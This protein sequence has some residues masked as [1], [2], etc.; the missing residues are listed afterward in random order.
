MQVEG[1]HAR[2][3]LQLGDSGIVIKDQVFAQVTSLNGKFQTCSGEEGLLGLGFS[4][5]SSHN[6]PTVL[7][8][9]KDILRYPIFAMY[10]DGTDDYPANGVA[11][12]T[13]P[14]GDAGPTPTASGDSGSS[15]YS[16]ATSA[17]S[18]I[19]FGGVNGRLYE[20][21]ITWHGL[22]KFQNMQTGEKFEGYWDFA[23]EKV[24][25]GGLPIP[26]SSLA[27]VD[28]GS[29]FILGPPD[30]VSALAQLDG[31]V[32]LDLTVPTAPQ[33]VPC[34]SAEGFDAAVLDCNSPVFSV[35]LIADGTTYTL[36]KE[37]IVVELDTG[38]DSPICLLRMLPTFEFDGWILGD[39]FLNRHYAAF[40]FGNKKVG[41][42][43]SASSS[44]GA[45]I[46]Q[47][48][49]PMD[50]SNADGG[51]GGMPQEK[52]TSAPSPPTQAATSKAQAAA[53]ISEEE[54]EEPPSTIPETAP[55]TSVQAEKT[56]VSAT[57]ETSPSL[58]STP[59]PPP[60][61]P[62]PPPTLTRGG[63]GVSDAEKMFFGVVGVVAAGIV[64]VLLLTRRRKRYRRAAVFDSYVERHG[65][66]GLDLG[67]ELEMTAGGVLS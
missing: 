53:A 57:T 51:T 27:V 46:C 34:D 41:F 36:A 1:E 18:E 52:G 15:S 33:D 49:W 29:S 12:A 67:D 40:D 24:E 42:A 45:E 23:V 55:S 61:S 37:D 63:G 54:T 65:A 22:G 21:C 50:V 35:D 47:T 17:N 14:G 39:V 30:A 44:G 4:E 32:C 66:D 43:R 3:V 7:S 38:M 62:A 8:N 13:M 5:I 56:T 64:A 31:V 11:D 20:G 48:D 2:D 28:S 16:K 58:A 6:F 10:L 19:V 9:L 59:P 25:V 60:S 26:T